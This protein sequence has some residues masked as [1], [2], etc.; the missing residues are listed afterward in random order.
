MTLKDAEGSHVGCGYTL[1]MSNQSH[2]TDAHTH[3]HL[4]GVQGSEAFP[5]LELPLEMQALILGYLPLRDL[6]QL[7]CLGKN[8]RTVYW[9][10]VIERDAVVADLVKLHFTA[11]FRDSLRQVDT[12]L[13]RDLIVDPQ[14]RRPNLRDG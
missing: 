10:R 8:P 13:P 9:N 12:A 2:H 5:L 7:A 11:E 3:S 14:V 1:G 4:M 6:A